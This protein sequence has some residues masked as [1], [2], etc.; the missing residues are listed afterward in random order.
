MPND[1]D[2]YLGL[3]PE[4]PLVNRFASVIGTVLM[5]L[6]GRWFGTAVVVSLAAIVGSEIKSWP[7]GV[8]FG[9]AAVGVFLI[10]GSLSGAIMSFVLRMVMGRPAF[11]RI[12]APRHNLIAGMKSA[13]AWSYEFDPE[14]W[15]KVREFMKLDDEILEENLKVAYKAAYVE[16]PGGLDDEVASSA[17]SE[18]DF[19]AR[20]P[21]VWKTILD[22]PL[23]GH[24]LRN[25][26]A[27]EKFASRAMIALLPALTWLV[28]P[29]VDIIYLTMIVLT[30]LYLHG[31]VELLNVVQ[32]GVA[33]LFILSITLFILLSQKIVGHVHFY[34]EQM[35]LGEEI[36]RKYSDRLAAIRNQ[37]V[38]PSARLTN[39][40]LYLSITRGYFIRILSISFQTSLAVLLLV[41][42]AVVASILLA[43]GD[44]DSFLP[45][46][47]DFSIGVVLLPVAMIVGFFVTFEILQRLKQLLAP[48]ALGALG[49]VAPFA[50]VYLSTGR[51]EP[52]ELQNDLVGVLAGAG[53]L[54]VGFLT[55]RT[56][57]DMEA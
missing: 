16:N 7:S 23:E 57:K 56:A 19:E 6:Q 2:E 41:A 53:G 40:S 46:Y 31:S 44:R 48:L 52:N 30:A 10:L 25:A 13:D 50:V 21:A 14:D 51:F 17:P 5:K 29:L 32:V 42:A 15:Q 11:G 18:G 1:K 28:K 55:S 34:P 9:F 54:A 27:E 38:K 8:L 24:T 49:V 43:S 35:P 45:W 4:V 33:L 36:E 12:G 47:R 3:G 26:L 20:W 22:V 39:T 37:T